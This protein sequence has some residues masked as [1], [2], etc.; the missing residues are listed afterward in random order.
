MGGIDAGDSTFA[1]AVIWRVLYGVNAILGRRYRELVALALLVAAGGG[2][3][4]VWPGP[5]SIAT[6]EA[7]QN[8]EISLMEVDLFTNAQTAEASRDGS[9]ARLRVRE[10]GFAPNRPDGMESMGA[11]RI[12]GEVPRGWRVYADPA[13]DMELVSE[14]IR[15]R[16]PVYRL[17]P[18][19][20]GAG[21]YFI[22]PG[23]GEGLDA[24]RV[25]RAEASLLRSNMR[26]LEAVVIALR[27]IFPDVDSGSDFEAEGEKE[28]NSRGR[29]K[30]AERDG[31]QQPDFGS[32]EG[33]P[34]DRRGLRADRQRRKKAEADESI[35][36][37][38]AP[39]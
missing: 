26:R 9:S 24:A 15:V 11:P 36:L 2:A 30:G 32:L 13:A 7:E 22:E 20:I 4:W 14:G 6:E 10:S 37:P 17:I 28:G 18:E 38:D 31:G 12:I 8:Q 34:D 25:L 33:K 29:G 23:Y 27:E 39:E 19:H 35:P 5:S 21:T 16:S 3:V 1:G